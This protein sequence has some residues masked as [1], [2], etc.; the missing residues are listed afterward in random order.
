MLPNQLSSSPLS[1]GLERAG[2]PF[3]SRAENALGTR[4]PVFSFPI[5]TTA[6]LRSLFGQRSK[7]YKLVSIVAPTGYGKTVL[8]SML[9]YDCVKSQ[10]AGWWFANDERDVTMERLLGYLEECLDIW[11][12]ASG[13]LSPLQVMHEGTVP[14]RDRI[15]RLIRRMGGLQLPVTLFIEN[16]D[17]CDDPAL[18]IL[19][20]DLLY[21]TP[22]WFR[23]VM[24]SSKELPIE[25][26]RCKLEG[27][28]AEYRAADLS[29]D[30]EGVRDVLGEALCARLSEASMQLIVSQT[31]G[32]P[33]AVRLMQILLSSASSPEATLASF[34]GAD[35]DIASLLNSRVLC[36]FDP[37]MGE[38]LLKISCLRDFD[39]QLACQASG[40]SDASEHLR[41]LWKHNVFLIPV[42]GQGRLR[43]HNLFR[44][45]LAAQAARQLSDECRK[46]IL[47]RASECCEKQM[48]RADAIDYAFLADSVS[49]AAGMLERSAALFVRD[50]GYL[51]RYLMWIDKLHDA[52]LY[53]G[54]ETDYWYV[55]ALVFCR[56]YGQARQE[57]AR[58]RAR[59]RSAADE[60]KLDAAY[61]AALSRR[62]D[63]LRIAID[64]YT[65]HLSGLEQE[66]SKW[67]QAGDR[68]EVDAG[69]APFDTA[70]VACAGG[71]CH[72]NEYRLVAARNMAQVAFANMA[73]SNSAYGQA[74]VAVLN[75][76]I[77][78]REGDYA[79][80]W[81]GLMEALRQAD[82]D[83]SQHEGICGTLAL[84]GAKC[85][86][87][88]DLREEAEQLLGRGLRTISTHGIV[89][90]AAYGL[91]AAVTLWASRSEDGTRLATLRKVAAAYPVRLNRMMSCFIVRRMIV[92]GR[93]DEAIAEAA[94]LGIDPEAD[95][96]AAGG[97]EGI[98]GRVMSDLM[99]ATSTDLLIAS[100]KL[101]RASAL[102]AEEMP[103]ATEE[104][105]GARLVELELDQAFLSRFSD[106][107][108]RAAHHLM[109]AISLAAR[110]RYLRPFRDRADL[111]A[112]LVNETKQKDWPF[113]TDEE[114]SFFGEVCSGLITKG[115][116][117]PEPVPLLSSGGMEVPTER[118]RELLGL[119]ASGLSN[120]EIADTLS[121]SVATV[122]WHLY[123]LYA[124]LGVKNRASALAR[125]RALRL[126]VR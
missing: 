83:L 2:L 85:A 68:S 77:L 92:L 1:T 58:L 110:R 95:V 106:N 25:V 88:M 118:E 13:A 102:I 84:L 45:Y 55:W 14:A 90:T 105:C 36:G 103:R 31:E 75:A 115:S 42:E 34:S 17:Y 9:Y 11:G 81:Q 111:M 47:L 53:G 82:R 10:K 89:D 119:L 74:W 64:V 8:M 116:R 50:M 30:M 59:L 6:A 46:Q 51:P 78:L 7:T 70:I 28:L 117:V 49:V 62:M 113:V 29:L 73:Q 122:K 19:L 40:D 60:R 124:K 98:C 4:A 57:M 114:R 35:E 48:R 16:V 93:V 54:L 100:G 86:I 37:R 3:A 87:E 27:Q 22:H 61:L 125:A 18:G 20:S 44:E 39:E 56:R 96:S 121:L 99:R 101:K 80:A 76:Q 41:Y 24:S 126:L 94:A 72:V 91:D 32:W 79:A 33:A 26:V 12:G 123:N 43:F 5:A 52:G 38:F 67:L 23:L 109:R 66:V 63:V 120:Q 71:L 21:R 108:G 69:D 107:Y 65:D 97:S 15:D 112:E 104:R